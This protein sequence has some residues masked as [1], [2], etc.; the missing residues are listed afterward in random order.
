LPE[1]GQTNWRDGRWW[2]Q[3]EDRLHDTI[4][5]IAVETR[6]LQMPRYDSYQRFAVLY[7]RMSANTWTGPVLHAGSGPDRRLA[8]N[9]V[10]NCADAF[11]SKM[12]QERPKVTF[13][14]SGGDHELQDCAK[15]LEKFVDGQFY[16]M[17]VYEKA[18]KVV[19]HSCIAGTGVLRIFIHGHGDKACV[20]CEPVLADEL[21]VD[22]TDG[23]YG[24][25]TW[26]IYR[27]LI[28]KLVL[29]Q[30]FPEFAE[31]IER[32]PPTQSDDYWPTAIESTAERVPIYMAWHLR[33]GQDATDGK[34]AICI[35]GKTLYFGEWNYDYFPFAFYRRQWAPFGFWGIGLAEELAGIQLEVNALAQK[36]QRHHYLLG[37]GHWMVENNSRVAQGQ[38]DNDISIIRYS[39]VKPD[40]VFPS[41]V[42]PDM[43]QHLW[44]LYGKAYEITG[45]SQLAAS[46][47][48]P[49]GLNSGKALD[50]YADIT[51][52]RF[53]VSVRAYQD[54]YLEIAR[55]VIDR[56][57]EIV[58]N[59]NKQYSVRAVSKNAMQHVKF[60]DV[61]LKETEAVL[62]MYP[63]NKLAKD[64]AE[65]MAQVQQMAN[66]GW[67]DPSAAKRLLD[68]PDLE[69]EQ[70]YAQANYDL[71]MK[72]I[73]A[74]VKDGK[75]TEP[76]PFL[77]IGKV[78]QGEFLPGETLKLAQMAELRGEFINVPEPNLEM[79]RKWMVAAKN[80]V[81]PE[82]EE[83]PPAPAPL[84]AGPMPPPPGIP[85]SGGPPPEGIAPAPPTMA[86]MP[87]NG[88]PS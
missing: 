6:R 48:K 17:R 41:V 63:T 82:P 65:R 38:L 88:R 21:I 70:T 32:M 13:L 8:L 7:N 29:M 44:S 85:P 30:E 83:Q 20:D 77:D 76:R 1:A 16:E 81:A 74:I 10:K 3:D 28:D 35:H 46:S 11:T 4:Y 49:Q 22:D 31:E 9:I 86:P 52:E 37:S 54:W 39:G 5:R 43:Y 80:L 60:L 40:I 33:S 68:F 14:T 42:P 61:D 69:A 58:A 2:L 59:D 50:A 64:P 27:R 53:A 75:W 73:D 15:D 47:M 12:T 24:Q 67:I 78:V 66:A 55:Q 26:V 18:P 62:Q 51:S 72:I 19:L 79:L 56:A 87:G 71:S 57:R 36:I 34:H 45:I 84:P 25:P 23:K